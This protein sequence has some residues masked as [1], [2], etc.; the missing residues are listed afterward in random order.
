MLFGKYAGIIAINIQ[1]I[2]FEI[3]LTNRARYEKSYKII[4]NCVKPIYAVDENPKN[5][6][7]CK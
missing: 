7:I 4:T 2:T 1:K 6:H 5:K 3:E